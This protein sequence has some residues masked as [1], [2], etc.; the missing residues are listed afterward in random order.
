MISNDL[1]KYDSFDDMEL[2]S[3]LLRN[4][5]AMG[6]ERPSHIQSYGIVP[7]TQHK[8]ILAQSQSG[9]G[10]TG[11][12]L[13]G[14]I[15][16]IDPSIKHPQTLI[17]VPT[18]ELAIQIHSIVEQLVKHMDIQYSLCVGGMDIDKNNREKIKSQIIVGT[19]GRINKLIEINLLITTNIHMLVLDEMDELLSDDFSAQMKSIIDRL[20]YDTQKIFFSATLKEQTQKICDILM[21]DNYSKILL[22]SDEIT[23]DG[24]NQFFINVIHDNQKL[25][26]L[27]DLYAKISISQ[28]II[29]VNTIKRGEWLHN[30]LIER[31]HAVS[32]IH[33]NFKL[34]DRKRILSSFARG[35]TRVLISTDLLARGIDIQQISV[36]I[37]YDIPFDIENYIHRIGRSGRFGRKGCGINFVTMNDI[38]QIKKIEQF[39]D[40][41][42]KPFKE[43]EF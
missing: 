37:N 10:K 28:S 12:F 5:Y 9:T 17:I 3:R 26:T 23:L 27:I 13:I 18:R 7:I 25:D 29:Y 21:K 6:F 30:R 40:T 34:Q 42:I 11:A 24:I 43:D 19:P 15:Q 32:L 38:D 14:T 20:S 1:E 2:N 33:S 22:N 4:I 35:E 8:D 39:Y 16:N 36:V 31:G 41:E